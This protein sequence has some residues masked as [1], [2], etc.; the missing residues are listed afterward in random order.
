MSADAFG[1]RPLD[2]RHGRV[3]LNHGAGGRASAQLIE[4]LFVRAFDNAPLRA[5]DD[6]AV[7]DA[8]PAG[9]RLVVATDAHVISP[10]FFPGGDIGSL[11]VH[12]T[13]N[14]VAMMGASP[15]WMTASFVIEEGLALADLARI[16]ASMAAAARACGVAVVAGDTKVVERGK[17]DGVFVS[18]TGV[19]WLPAGRRIGGALAA[20]GDA[21]LLT[22]PIGR[23][24]VAVMSRRAGLAFDTTIVSDTAPLNGL[25]DGLLRALPEGSVHALRDPTRGG[26]AAAL[27]EIAR[28]SGVGISIDEAAIPIDPP[29]RAACELFGLDP[30]HVANEGCCVAICAPAHAADALEALRAHPLGRDARRI[31]SVGDATDRFVQMRTALGGRRVVD[32]PSGEP[33]PRIC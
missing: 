4:Q 22:G 27:N 3:D 21:V 32:W 20:P 10:L 9:H 17:G 30:L 18:T 2:L 19:G 8:P 28:Q 1:L 15:R 23:H 29:V 6:G 16:A 31:G 14:D 24:G 26:L 7:L 25:V 11:A 13:V 33:L 5:G 12:G